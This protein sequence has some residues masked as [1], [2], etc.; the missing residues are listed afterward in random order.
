LLRAVVHAAN[1]AEDDFDESV[2]DVIDNIAIGN[3]L[4][5]CCFVTYL[6]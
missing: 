6:L 2:A 4:R 5:P 3:Q 1:E